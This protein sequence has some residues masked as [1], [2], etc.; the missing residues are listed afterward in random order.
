MQ[1]LECP[2]DG[3]SATIEAE[4]EQEVMAQ[5]EEHA[6]SSHPELEL[7]DETVENIRSS[8]IQV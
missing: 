8:I 5:A 1:R 3:C 4:T 6:N 2:V 7:D